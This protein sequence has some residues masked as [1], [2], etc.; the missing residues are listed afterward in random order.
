[1]HG[2]SRRKLLVM[3][4]MTAV[5]SLIAPAAASNTQAGLTLRRTRY[6]MDETGQVWLWAQFLNDS[7]KPIAI[8][9]LAPSKAGPWSNVGQTAAPGTTL[10]GSMKVSDGGPSSLWVDSSVGLLRFDVPHSH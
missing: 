1:M 5:A 10:K 8:R 6:V 3:I 7:N 9:G 4:G 2:L